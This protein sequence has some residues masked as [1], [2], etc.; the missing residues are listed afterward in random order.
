MKKS[1]SLPLLFL[2]S[3]TIPFS[4]SFGLPAE[5]VQLVVDEQYFQVTK[6]MIQEAKSSILIM[7]FEMGYYESHPNTPSNILIHELI[8]AKK[9]GVRV[10]VILEVG[11]GMNRTTERNQKTGKILSD[12]GVHVIFDSILRTTHTK[13]MVVDGELVLIGSTNWTYYALT[14]NNELSVL[15]R[16]KELAKALTDYFNQV[17]AKGSKSLIKE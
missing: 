7:M 5:D 13:G 1:I 3:F 2:L 6:K 4:L 17:K 15:I 10:E 16:S 12:G 14:Q 9:R 11:E 8:K